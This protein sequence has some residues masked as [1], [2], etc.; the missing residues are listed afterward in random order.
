MF[1]TTLLEPVG[2]TN[3]AQAIDELI[4]KL[5]LD[6]PTASHQ[7]VTELVSS[8]HA[9]FEDAP[10]REFIPLLVERSARDVLEQAA[11]APSWTT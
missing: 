4:H 9:R 10:I 8:V 1:V 3:E 11:T 5:E 6:Y 2:R 7:S